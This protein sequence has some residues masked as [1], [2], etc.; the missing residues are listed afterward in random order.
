MSYKSSFISG[1]YK[2]DCDVCGRTYK[3][4]KLKK[5]WDGLFVCNLDYEVRHPQ[6]F[7]RGTVDTQVPPWTRPEPA[8]TFAFLSGSLL[9]LENSTADYLNYL[10][11][12]TN[13]LLQTET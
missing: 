8:D 12:E 6:D 10:T 9:L 3:A 7:V 4:S 11:T 13:N 1:E 5:R 2:A